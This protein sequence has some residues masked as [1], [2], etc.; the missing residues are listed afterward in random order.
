MACDDQLWP[1]QHLRDVRDVPDRARRVKAMFDAVARRYD[2]FNTLAS[3]GLDHFWRARLIRQAGR[4][5]GKAVLDLCCGPGTLTVLLGERRHRA[6]VVVGAD[7]SE[8]MLRLA[9]DRVG[10]KAD[11][12]RMC[13]ADALTLPFGDQTFDLATC[14][15][16][17]R[18]FQDLAAG[19][20]ELHRVLKSPSQVLILEFAMPVGRGF[21]FVYRLYLRYIMPLIGRLVAGDRVRAYEYLPNSVAAFDRP[22]QLCRAFR[23]AGFRLEAA[24]PLTGGAVWMYDLRKR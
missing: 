19:L 4:L 2:L 11:N 23:Q 7:F 21:R 18:N 5:A 1:D 13:C 3:F 22:Q 8:Q 14:T 9:D 12:I 6:R 20:R 24:V 15:F 17:I 10:P 16:G